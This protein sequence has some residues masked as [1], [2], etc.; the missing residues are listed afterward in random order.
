MRNVLRARR[1]FTPWKNLKSLAKYFTKPA[2]D[3]T[4]AIINWDADEQ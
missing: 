2:L 3:V 4:D 1:R